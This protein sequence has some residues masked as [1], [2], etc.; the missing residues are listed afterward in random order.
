MLLPQ[1]LELLQHEAAVR[2]GGTV[3]HIHLPAGRGSRSSVSGGEGLLCKTASTWLGLR[4]SG[5]LAAATLS[6]H[7]LMPMHGS[8]QFQLTTFQIAGKRAIR[9]PSAYRRALLRTKSRSKGVQVNTLTLAS[10][11]RCT[12]ILSLCPSTTT[13]RL[14]RGLPPPLP[15]LF[16]L[17]L[18][19]LPPPLAPAA[20]GGPLGP[21][22]RRR[23]C[24][25]ACFTGGV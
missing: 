22:A 2:F 1:L 16:P 23:G 10:T 24:C 13:G 14:N 6:L 21:V 8:A 4:G 9:S 19:L 7:C 17:L 20:V 25:A 3:Q 18:L 12:A 5:G 11:A 15:V